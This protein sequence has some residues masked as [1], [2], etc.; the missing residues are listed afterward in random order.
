MPPIPISDHGL[1]VAY[2]SGASVTAWRDIVRLQRRA[3]RRNGVTFVDLLVAVFVTALGTAAVLGLLSAA[4]QLS[5]GNQYYLMAQQIAR[6]EMEAIRS[7][8]GYVLSNRTNAPLIS[9]P[10]LLSQL[11]S[12]TATLTIADSATLTG[13]KDITVTVQW[14]QPPSNTQKTI[15][16]KT[17]VSPNGPTS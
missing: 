16:L 6:G 2:A 8:K 14:L 1:C 3:R 15:T 9:S 17:L 4:S 10:S 7:T 11:P 12:G 13:A 5:T